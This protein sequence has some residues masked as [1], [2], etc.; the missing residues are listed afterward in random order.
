MKLLDWI[1][2]NRPGNISEYDDRFE[3]EHQS[4]EHSTVFK[5]AEANANIVTMNSLKPLGDT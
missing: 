1:K 4:G 3:I 5:N 2:A